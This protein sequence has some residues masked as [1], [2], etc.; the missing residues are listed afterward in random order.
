[1]NI[2][3]PKV[4]IF[5]GNVPYSENKSGGY[6]VLLHLLIFKTPNYLYIFSLKN[7][8]YFLINLI[9]YLTKNYYKF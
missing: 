7:K 1:M 8:Y 2:I 6:I 5:C 4:C 9:N 3:Y